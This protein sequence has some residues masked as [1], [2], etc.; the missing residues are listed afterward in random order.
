MRLEVSAGA[1]SA[2]KLMYQDS[3]GCSECAFYN[4]KGEIEHKLSSGY[5]HEGI[6]HLNK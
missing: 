1:A 6:I 2:V 3:L 4:R 5:I